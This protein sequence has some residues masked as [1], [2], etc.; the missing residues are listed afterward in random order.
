MDNLARVHYKTPMTA[1]SF[2]YFYQNLSHFL[3][4]HRF[5]ETYQYALY[6]SGKLFRP[7]LFLKLLNDFEIRH[8]SDHYF[9]ASALEVHHTYT[10]LHDDLPCMDNDDYR[11]GK[12]STH[13]KFGEWQAVLAGDGLLNFSYELL[14]QMKASPIH[15][16]LRIF[17]RYLGP[18]GLILG[19]AMDLGEKQKSV[20]EYLKLHE[21]K[22]ARLIQVSCL[23]AA[24]AGNLDFK[25]KWA[26][27]SLGKDLGL[28]FQ[29]LDDLSDFTDNTMDSANIFMTSSNEILDYSINLLNQIENCMSKY[30][31]EETKKYFGIYLSKTVND[32]QSKKLIEP[33]TLFLDL[34]NQRLRFFQR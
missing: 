20:A 1:V 2:E 27:W 11:R 32:L 23:S 15:K 30:S 5:T 3:P 25:K 10:L 16:Y 31:L 21:L 17:S 8:H 14:S 7:Q 9:L 4:K 19:Q 13:K 18:Q 33:V 12:L 22:T 28:L 34:L 6:P 26:M 24:V 29:I